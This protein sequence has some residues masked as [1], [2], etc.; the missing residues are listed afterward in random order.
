MKFR[1]IFATTCVLAAFGATS[2]LAGAPDDPG[3]GGQA[4]KE[5]VQFY[6]DLGMTF[7]EAVSEYVQTTDATLGGEVSALNEPNPANDNG[8]GND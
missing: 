6:R 7:G 1:H 2:A 4:V 5:A 8:G 3:L